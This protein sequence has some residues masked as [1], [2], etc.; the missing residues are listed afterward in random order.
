VSIFLVLSYFILFH[1]FVTFYLCFQE[2][3]F[4]H[5]NC[6]SFGLFW[7]RFSERGKIFAKQEV[8]AIQTGPGG[9]FFTGDGSGQ[10]K[11]WQW[12]AEPTAT[13]R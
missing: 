2:P 13:T 12:L 9:L 7:F 4:I 3:P 11:V 1:S 8:R 10:V 5:Y 6:V